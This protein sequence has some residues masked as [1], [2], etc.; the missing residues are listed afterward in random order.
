M[1]R[2]KLLHMG[3]QADIGEHIK[4]EYLHIRSDDTVAYI[5]A[6]CHT[7]VLGY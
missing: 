4:N 7:I 5:Q 3:P 2:R 1:E 6:G